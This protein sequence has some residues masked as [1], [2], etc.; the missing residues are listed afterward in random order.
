MALNLREGRNG[1]RGRGLRTND[2]PRPD[3]TIVEKLVLPKANRGIV[4]N[5]DLRNFLTVADNAPL[6]DALHE[7][8]D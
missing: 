6:F 2:M 5:N 8:I 4:E 3:L 7:N 1:A